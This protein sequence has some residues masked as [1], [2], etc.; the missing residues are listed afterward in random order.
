LGALAAV[1]V[2]ATPVI[3]RVRRLASGLLP[4]TIAPHSTRF[5]ADFDTG[6][7]GTPENPAEITGEV[8]LLVA[9]EAPRSVPGRYRL[10]PALLWPFLQLVKA[11]RTRPPAGYRGE[12]ASIAGRQ[13]TIRWERDP[14][15]DRTR[16]PRGAATASG[17][18]SLRS[19][20]VAQPWERI[21]SESIG[22][23]AIGRIEWVRGLV[24]S[25]TP[26]QV[27][28][29]DVAI[30]A[31]SAWSGAVGR[32]YAA[33]GAGPQGVLHVIG[34]AVATSAGPRLDVAGEAASSSG[35]AEL[36]DPRGLLEGRPAFVVIQAEPT[37]QQVEAGLRD[38]TPERLA[39][40]AELIESGA[41]A[42]LV[43]PALPADLALAVASAVAVWDRTDPATAARR[44]ASVVRRGLRD[45]VEPAF[46]DDIVLF[47]NGGRG[48][49]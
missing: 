21:L 37:D 16:W 49:E 23:G 4:K 39:L 35:T 13:A 27:G 34:R 41:P 40:A 6:H 28:H 44:A 48:D 25:A 18:I 12:Y 38:D 29:T 26:Y 32:T 46:L 1:L 7:V 47:V 11:V 9:A 15:E 36:R 24:T 17:T 42:V 43:V 3:R 2:A 33:A 22:P 14:A 30:E 31:P 20:L 19:S 10:V 8:R 5:A 45:H